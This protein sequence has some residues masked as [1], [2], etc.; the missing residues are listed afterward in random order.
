MPVSQYVLKVH[1][2]CDLACDFCYVYTHADQG[3][4]H[5]P[6]LMSPQIVERS[7]ERIAE[8]A[9]VYGLS[10]V[11]VVLHGGE[12]LLIG[13]NRAR[14][15]L[16][17]LKS[18]I[19]PVARLEI[20]IHTNGVRL[21][22]QWC[23]LFAEYGVHVGVSLD[24]DKAANDRHRLFRGGQSSHPQVMRA[25][26]LL[27]QSRYRH[28][29]AGILC[30]IDIANDPVVVYEALIEQQPPR[31]D[32]LLP[33]AT[34]E[35]PPLRPSEQPHPYA[36]WLLA[37]YHRWI[38]DSR[39]VPIRFFDS[40][41][42]AAA[43]G[44]SYTESLGTDPVG[45]LV[46]ETDG[47]WEQPDSMKTAF[48]GA[49]G[50]GTH[51]LTHRV[52]EAARHPWIQER[53]NG[54][55]ALCPTCQACP[56]VSVCGGGL[57]AHRYRDDGSGF[58]NPSAYCAD[59]FELIDRMLAAERVRREAERA[60]GGHRL[61]DVAL[62]RFAAGPG[63]AEGFAELALMRLRQ[64]R[65]LVAAVAERGRQAGDPRVRTTA[66]QG[67]ELL[68]ELDREH[69]VA[70]NSVLMHPYVYAWAMRCM[71]GTG[72]ADEPGLSH[73]AGIALAAALRAGIAARLPVPVREGMLHLP[74]AGSLAIPDPPGG[75]AVVTVSES[76]EVSARPA[77][78]WQP[79]RMLT[80]AGHQPV[81][82]ED[83]DPFRDCQRW[84]VSGR[85]DDAQWEQWQERFGAAWRVLTD[86]V[87]EHAAVLGTGLRTIVP[88]RTD[89]R[90]HQAATAHDAFGAIG[91]GLPHSPVDLAELMLHEF[92]H[93]KLHA[94]LDMREL[95][96]PTDVRT[97][98]VP[99]RADPRPVE[100]VL[101]GAYAF[102]TLAQFYGGLPDGGPRHRRYRDW[103]HE[104]LGTLAASGALTPDG[105]LFVGVAGRAV[106][107]GGAAWKAG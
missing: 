6:R 7:A 103:V 80:R 26:S 107:G 84:P 88:L 105:E 14:E 102:M 36:D 81:A 29:Y 40:L 48:D 34:W 85:L 20:S 68:C 4:R 57:Y 16:A 65:A 2:R 15:V 78:T 21:D 99:W 97:F 56:V 41:L 23:D 28:L 62:R 37:I 66:A 33:H 72:G 32:L 82:L 74:S 10:E 58:A 13:P 8:H 45:M 9:A 73:L 53:Q 87:P 70:V 47:G 19:T 96:D 30:T 76:G 17:T 69:R 89:S 100:G 11:G 64:T 49:A 79:V 77:G 55:E 83:T 1:G 101:H 59:L 93:V 50:T 22:E 18:V 61:T 98:A 71:R 5:R 86:T 27:R 75:F 38:R 104:G 43:G 44:P 3:W 39:R 46:V 35:H 24:G 54:I 51:V 95:Y 63:D 31:I 12:P 91:V 106:D 92:Q 67:W 94:V 52:D 60:R 90:R 25:L 42:S